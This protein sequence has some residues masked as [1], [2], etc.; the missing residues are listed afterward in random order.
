MVVYHHA[1]YSELA[2]A[3]DNMDVVRNDVLD[4]L[5]KHI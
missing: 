3:N 5:E 4:L 2:K 1:T